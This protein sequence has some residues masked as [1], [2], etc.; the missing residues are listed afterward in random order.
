M[1]KIDN[2]M[3]EFKEVA[4]WADFAQAQQNTILDLSKKNQQLMDEVT[5]LKTLIESTTPVLATDSPFSLVTT[6]GED[7][8]SIC[9][10]EISKLR[11]ISCKQPLSYQETK[12]LESY[13]NILSKLKEQP[14]TIIPK[15]KTVQTHD[16]LAIAES[17]NDK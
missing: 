16:L 17:F 9:R 4:D 1:F 6:Q 5:H 2:L 3:K 15:A 8:E 7:E 11:D 14:K 10:M 13:V 12:Q